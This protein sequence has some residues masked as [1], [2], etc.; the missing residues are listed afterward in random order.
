MTT[1]LEKPAP[2]KRRGRALVWIGGI[3]GAIL[4]AD[5]AFALVSLALYSDT[6]R[7]TSTAEHS[8]DAAP[9]VELVADGDVTVASGGTQVLVT[10][11][12]RTALTSARYSVDQS[13]DRLTVTHECT[14]WWGSCSAA[15]RV[16][17]PQG[18]DVVIRASDGHVRASG[19]A[20]SLDIRAGDGRVDVATVAGP[21]AIDA[22]DGVVDVRDVDGSVSVA[23]GDGR[24]EV[25]GVTGDL[26]AT[27]AD[28]HVVV[29]AVSGNIDLEAGDGS[30][31]VYGTGVPVALDIRTD[32]GRQVVDAPTDPAADVHVSIVAHD[33]NVAYRG[34][35]G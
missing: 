6:D 17:V 14:S 5:G 30:V 3:V 23:S 28:G 10:S 15:L 21:V 20:G 19:L 27:V 7:A 22:S 13:A 8:Y 31:E 9:T 25:D 35:R 12:A 32:D 1:T 29:E 2:T 4:L 16:S 24:L 33:G 26:G 34:P 11:I 18:T